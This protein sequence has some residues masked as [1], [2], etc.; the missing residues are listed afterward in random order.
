MAKKGACVGRSVGLAANTFSPS[1]AGFVGTLQMTDIT[2]TTGNQFVDSHCHI[3][4]LEFDADREEVIARAH[5]ARVTSMLNV[6]TGDP[7]SAVFERALALAP[8]PP[9]THPPLSAP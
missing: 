8:N 7:H 2:Q 4:G 9:S 3:D 5:D 6:G 1:A